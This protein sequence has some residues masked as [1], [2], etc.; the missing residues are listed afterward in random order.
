MRDD[1]PETKKW[2]LKRLAFLRQ[3]SVWI[4]GFGESRIFTPEE[5]NIVTLL[6]QVA[7]K[8][9]VTAVSDLGGDSSS[10][11]MCHFGNKT[12]DYFRKKVGFASETKVEEQDRQ[13]P[14]LR[15]IASD[16]LSRSAKREEDKTF[17]APVEV[18]VFQQINDELEYI[19]SRIK[20]MVQFSGY[21]YRDVTVVLCNPEKYESCLHAAFA[22]YGLD[23]FLDTRCTMI[24]T[25]FMQYVQS[26][27]DML[28]YNWNLSF[29]MN[30]LKSGFVYL[31]AA[32]LD[33][34]ENYCLLHGIKNKKRMLDCLSYAKTD[35]EKM[36]FENV[37][38]VIADLDVNL[39]EISKKKTCR[40]KAVALH[41][42]VVLQKEKTEAFVDEWSKVN[43]ESALALAASYNTLDDALLALAGPIGDFEITDE[44]FADAVLSAVSSKALRRIPSFVD[45]ITVTDPANAY[46][47]PCRALFIVGPDRKTFPYSSPSEGY[48]KN[49]E[50]ELISER[51]SM[52]F[53]NHAKDQAYSDFFAA[54]ALLQA[55]SDRIIFTV[56]NSVEPSSMVLFLKENYPAIGSIGMEHLSLSD[57]RIL[58]KEGMRDYL[59]DV[60]TSRIQVEEEEKKKAILL[61]K[62]YFNGED[63]SSTGEQDTSLSIP[64]EDIEARMSGELKM[65]VSSIENYVKCP[66]NYFCERILG[67]KE[68]QVQ[69]VQATEMGSLAHTVMQ[70]ALT[71][72]S[73]EVCKAESKEEKKKVYEQ[74]AGKD[75]LSWARELLA[76]A[77]TTSD[78][79]YAYVEDPAMKMEADERT[80]HALAETLTETFQNIGQS[81]FVPMYFEKEFGKDDIPPYEIT[82]SDKRKVSFTGTVDR[83]DVDPD[84]KSFQILDYK[85]GKKT[86]N[87]SD[88]MAGISVQL[89]AYTIMSQEL[90]LKEL[91]PSGMS[92]VH[93]TTADTKTDFLASSFSEEDKE[94]ARESSL[95]KAFREYNYSLMADSEALKILGEY[96]VERIRENC[97]KLFAGQFPSQPAKNKKNAEFDC[98]KCAYAFICNRDP[99]VPDYNFLPRFIAPGKKEDRRRDEF[100]SQLKGEDKSQLKGEDKK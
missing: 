56:Q 8:V 34:F 21:R 30:Y 100:I 18:R 67:V 75:M 60:L 74:Y 70:K 89:P 93:V 61:W 62:K 19:A 94:K 29:M 37:Q 95:K 92:Y 83:V 5:Y 25:S 42:F 88:L 77:Q 54:S 43:Q 36:Y 12:V 16:Y 59:R 3:S 57:P 79:Y 71:Q 80:L 33:R 20:E 32:K 68:R 65:S 98:K 4:L 84:S 63:L 26:V 13:D 51:L 55:P 28:R 24:G 6:S 10:N 7:E 11:D 15:K 78:E 72:Y 53:P 86:I 81:T 90:F 85:T 97:E 46:R 38:K 41:D 45:Q 99:D 58:E 69:M 14:A 9:T 66:Y 22:R 48:L 1:A 73:D 49:R 52:D 31:S 82:L 23:T 2:P 64:P 39:R 96:A 44:N 17:T 76:E 35:Y 87:Y 40:E 50:R 91:N 47:R 27:L